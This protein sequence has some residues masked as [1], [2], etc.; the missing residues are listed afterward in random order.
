MTSVRVTQ[1]S[2]ETSAG[3]L[4]ARRN[5]ENDFAA[6]PAPASPS[7]TRQRRSVKSPPVF[8]SDTPV[9]R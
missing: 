5:A 1:T 3:E 9:E 2:R 6:L 7:T 4:P 8:F